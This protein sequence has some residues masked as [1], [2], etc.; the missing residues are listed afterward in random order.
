MVKKILI[1]GLIVGFLSSV[2]YA[3]VKKKVDSFDSSTRIMSKVEYEGPEYPD[4]LGIGIFRFV[5]FQKIISPSGVSK[6]YSLLLSRI[7]K[8]WC[9]F[10]RTPLEM[11][12]G[13]KIYYPPILETDSK[14]LSEVDPLMGIF[15]YGHGTLGRHLFTEGGWRIEGEMIRKILEADSITVR[16]NYSQHPPTTW[17]IPLK[18]LNEWKQV[19]REKF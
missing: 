1:A 19:I 12:I 7:D 15:D 13:K 11:K 6:Y 14:I 4:I 10:E 3:E 18:I 16:V 17:T 9:F 8:E 5:I 2:G